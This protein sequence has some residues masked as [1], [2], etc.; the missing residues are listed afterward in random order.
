MP[1][2]WTRT[3]SRTPVAAITGNGVVTTIAAKPVANAALIVIF[4]ETSCKKGGV[5]PRF[6]H[7]ER[8]SL[9]PG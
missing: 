5:T 2:C 4:I 7:H 8:S 3:C 1:A 6:C 9:S